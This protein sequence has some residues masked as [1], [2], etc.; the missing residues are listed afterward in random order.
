MS[1]GYHG[2]DLPGEG[3]A[4][5]MWPR[6]S[7]R[8]DR[9]YYVREDTL[10]EV[11]VATGNELRLGAPRDLFK[12]KPLGWSLIFGWPAGFDMS[13][14]GQRFV[15]AEPVSSKADLGGIVLVESWSREFAK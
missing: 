7:R 14:D 11:D 12:R 13:A 9:L 8:G 5:G 1:Q 15:V 4:A 2:G 3:A 10:V 6:W